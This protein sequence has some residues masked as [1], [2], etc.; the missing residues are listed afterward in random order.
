M[1]MDDGMKEVL[2]SAV[3]VNGWHVTADT[4]VAIGKLIEGGY[5]T[6]EDDYEG[7]RLSPTDKARKLAVKLKLVKYREDRGDYINYA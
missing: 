6:A 3:I 4:L 5:L 1:K 2:A 7:P